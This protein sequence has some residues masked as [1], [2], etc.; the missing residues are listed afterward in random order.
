MASSSSMA[1][2]T[3]HYVVQAVVYSAMV[4]LFLMARYGGWWTDQDTSVLTRSITATVEKATIAPGQEAY[5]Y[6]FAYPVIS[7]FITAVSGVPAGFLQTS[8]YPLT[9]IGIA[10]AAFILFRELADSEL[11]AAV[12]TLLLCVQSDFLFVVFRGSHEKVTWTMVIIS[13]FLLIRSYRFVTRPAY[14]VV[15]VALFYLTAFALISSNTFFASTFVSALVVAFFGAHFVTTLRRK[16]VIVTRRIVR[17]GYVTLACSVLIFVFIFYLYTPARLSLRFLESAWEKVSAF[18]FNFEPQV[19]TFSAEQPYQYIASDWVDTRVY[20]GLTAFNWIV[21]VLS[22]GVW[23]SQTYSL[24]R[25]KT[26]MTLPSFLLWLL[27][28][29]NAA[30][31]VGA[32]LL[33]SSGAVGNMQVRLFPAVMLFAIPLLSQAIV[34]RLTTCAAPWRQALVLS[35]VLSYAVFSGAAMLRA[36]HDPL[37]NNKWMFYTEPEYYGLKWSDSNIRYAS[38]WVGWA[39]RLRMAAEMNFGMGSLG[40]GTYDVLQKGESTRYVLLSDVIQM[41]SLRVR[42]PLPDIRDE[43]KIYDNGK[44]SLYQY[45]PIT[46]YQR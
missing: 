11:A 3:S 14:F 35:L 5:G 6:G 32:V 7:A 1:R 26:A 21:L 25:R 13:T 15:Y 4:S 20:F 29:A 27:Y 31:L 19:S 38:V 46:P 22:F 36:T 17:I 28:T 16:E 10:L 34:H 44:V 45:R 18:L 41:E 33:D 9:F 12:A 30:Q 42:A 39:E 24:L 40:K 37:V 8:I 2:N 43:H 23:L